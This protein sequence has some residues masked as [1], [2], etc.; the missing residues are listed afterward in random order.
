MLLYSTAVF[1]LG[2]PAN[3]AGVYDPAPSLGSGP[4][5]REL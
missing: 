2:K 4:L 5:A 1:P 3:E